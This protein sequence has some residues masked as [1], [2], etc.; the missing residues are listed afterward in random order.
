MLCHECG[1]PT[2]IFLWLLC[3]RIAE[4]FSN[5]ECKNTDYH[6][7]DNPGRRF[8]EADSAVTDRRNTNEFCPC[9]FGEQMV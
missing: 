6:T 9:R 8:A 7:A 3:R 5:G 2:E 1:L 4:F